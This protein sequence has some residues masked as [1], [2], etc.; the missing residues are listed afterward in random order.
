MLRSAYQ[1]EGRQAKSDN[2]RTDYEGPAALQKFS[3]KRVSP[4]QAS[5]WTKAG[6]GVSP[7]PFGDFCAYKKLPGF[8]AGSPESQRAEK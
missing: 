6:A 1:P 4:L 5:D 7:A 2:H 3:G 8:G